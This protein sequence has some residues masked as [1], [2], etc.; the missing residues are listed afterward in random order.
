MEICLI[1]ESHGSLCHGENGKQTFSRNQNNVYLT[2]EP[3]DESCHV[4]RQKEM[5]TETE[6][7]EVA[8]G[9]CILTFSKSHSHFLAAS[10]I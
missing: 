10:I 8:E 5:L 9:L 7:A 4:G 6:K 3:I 2:K 1:T